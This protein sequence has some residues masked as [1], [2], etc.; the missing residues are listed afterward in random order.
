MEDKLFR[1]KHEL[2]EAFTQTR[3]LTVKMMQSQG[4]SDLF[5]F[6]R[7]VLGADMGESKIELAPFHKELCHFVQDRRDRKKLI[8]V[9][10]GHLKSTLITIGYSLFRIIEN[11]NVRIQII[12]ATWQVAVD[13]LSEI[14]KHL[15]KNENLIEAFGELAVEAP[16]WSQDRITLNRTLRGIKEPTVWA[17]GVESNLVGSHPDLLILD[18]LM[19]RDYAKSEEL[20]S[21]VILRYKDYLDL[22]EPGGQLIVIG[23]RWNDRD[24]YEWIL[25]PQNNVSQGFDTLIK[26]AFETDFSLKEVFF[27]DGG[28]S[29]ITN[30]LWPNKFDFKELRDRYQAK[31][32]YEFSSQY[33]NNPVPDET[34]DFRKDWFHYIEEDDWKGRST[35]RYMT[36]D[37]AISLKREADYT[38]IVIADVDFMGTIFIRHIEMVKVMPHELIDMIFRL[39][40]TYRPRQIGIELVAFQKV[41]Q[42][43]INE[44]MHQRNRPLPIVELKV[45]D[46]SKDERIRAL[47]P[48]YANGKI[49]HGKNVKNIGSL[50]DQL[51]RFPRGRHDDIAD[52]FAS[53]LDLIV[54]PRIFEEDE[55]RGQKRYLYGPL[56]R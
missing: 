36:I 44:Q 41:L 21:N 12:N 20:T 24:L 31:G 17:A 39:A 49:V 14:K 45:Q 5:F 23:T 29:L 7:Y 30:H 13:F 35:N 42:Y 54:P 26:P 48:L 19:N 51:L 11:P 8:L 40:E 10:R 18:D 3:E 53:M 47:Q 25:N 37:P 2:V 27:Q 1:S 4:R 55:G 43:S 16:E 22:L 15:L 34:A 6:N 38:A 46:R 9:P 33:L 28:E 32:P 52:A 50:E 56:N